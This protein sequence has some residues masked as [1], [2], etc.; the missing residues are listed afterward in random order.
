MSA[1]QRT[2]KNPR[3]GQP[4][5]AGT[6]RGLFADPARV[7]ATPLSCEFL[8]L[9][10]CADLYARN[11][12]RIMA[13]PAHVDEAEL[14]RQSARLLTRLKLAGPGALNKHSIRVGYD[15]HMRVEDPG[16]CIS[17]LRD[18]R[19]RLLCEMFWPHISDDLFAAIKSE[20]HIASPRVTGTLLEFAKAGNGR[21]G[22]LAQHALAIAHHNQAI[23]NEMAF[24]TGQT[25]WNKTHWELALRFWG[26]ALGSKAF[27]DYFAERAGAYDDFRVRPEDILALRTQ[28]PEIILRFNAMFAQIYAQRSKHE[29]TKSHLAFI[30]ACS[31]PAEVKT[32]VLRSAAQVLAGARLAP[33]IHQMNSDVMNRK[34]RVT[35]RSF[36]KLVT[37]LI[38]EAEE[39]YLYLSVTL[40]LPEEVVRFSEFDRLGEVILGGIEGKLDYDTDDRLR[41][42]YLAMLLYKRMLGL[43]LSGTLQRKMEQKTRENRGILYRDEFPLP[44]SVDVTRCWFLPDELA[45]PEKSI[46]MP[47]YRITGVE[48]ASVSWQSSKI[49]VPRS[50]LAAKAHKGKVSNDELLKHTRDPKY[51]RIQEQ[52]EALSA[53]LAAATQR[54]ERK[55]AAVVQQ[56]REKEK[57]ALMRIKEACADDE[58]AAHAYIAKKAKARDEEIA[59]AEAQRR[60]ARRKVETRHA[61][62]LAAAQEEYHKAVARR[63]RLPGFLRYNLPFCVGGCVIG[64]L[65]GFVMAMADIVPD[66]APQSVVPPVVAALG[67]VV[68]GSVVAL[69]I[70]SVLRRRKL[71][72]LRRPLDE[73]E[74]VI[75]E[76]KA[77]AD[78]VCDRAKA[79]A[80]RQY[81]AKIAKAQ[82]WLGKLERAKERVRK[83]A[84]ETIA[85][86]R[87]GQ[88]QTVARLKADAD[89]Q[90]RAL[91]SKLTRLKPKPE[92][93]KN[94]FP[95]YKKAK[96]NGYSDG[97]KPSQA[98]VDRRAKREVDSL[99]NSLTDRDKQVLY[100]IGQV[101]GEATLN[102]IVSGLLAASPAERRRKLNE[103]ASLLGPM[104]GL[105]DGFGRY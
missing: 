46:L 25:E 104:A 88:S 18:P 58:A 38:D 61:D 94:Q 83:R 23:A 32:K 36:S 76:E 16:A 15:E 35:R 99:M 85:V 54:E 74:E 13:L 29:A 81:K 105:F 11:G 91:S 6:D 56:E 84:E 62:A 3:G 50:E 78:K 89:R 20:R 86:L 47:I 71:K 103:L 100:L 1:M 42:L 19:R 49:L 59:V 5:G 60:Q 102:A 96:S 14:E 80:T 101:K 40:G 77:A 63:S 44:D 98:E 73:I 93:H 37:P 12:F 48:G 4:S 82:E 51:R 30:G 27:W 53:E 79:K 90:I 75:E 9:E 65:G 69:P 24:G 2:K 41:T 43:P 68:L 64:G 8:G 34:G 26:Q 33:L 7:L 67:F 92:S 21:E 57:A 72:A 22:V 66:A 55:M 70:G 31:F 39:V 17:Q 28:L 10:V 87:R 95:P 97:E 52:I 45:D